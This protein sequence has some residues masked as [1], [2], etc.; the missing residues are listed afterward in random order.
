MGSA[1]EVE[2]VVLR[3]GY[4]VE[5]RRDAEEETAVLGLSVQG[6]FVGERS[7]LSLV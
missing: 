2:G 6:D 4:A 1:K 3:L 7:D 5:A